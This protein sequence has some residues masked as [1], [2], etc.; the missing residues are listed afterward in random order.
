MRFIDFYE[1]D[2]IMTIVDNGDIKKKTYLNQRE[3]F[4]YSIKIKI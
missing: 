1:E 4:Y 3:N 2:V